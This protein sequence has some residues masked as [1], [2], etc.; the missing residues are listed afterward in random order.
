M[1]KKLIPTLAI[2][3]SI[4][5]G[6]QAAEGDKFLGFEFGVNY[7]LLD[8]SRYDGASM[9]FGLVLPVGQ[10]FD[11][12]VYV[13]KGAFTGKE[14][15]TRSEIETNVTELRFRVPVFESETQSVKLMLGMG[16]GEYNFDDFDD[17]ISGIVGDLGVNYA[18]FKTKS[19]PVKGELAL[20]ALYRW[21]E[22]T[23]VDT[24]LPG[25]TVDSM[26]GFIIGLSAGLY[27]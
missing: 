26:G 25:D 18:F 24:D 1:L 13:E 9:N 12:V 10:K 2:V 4:F 15:D 8:D 11:V 22:I 27:F 3:G 14:D 7:H 16:Y 20:N 17:E 21:S 5:T 6:A 19:G 23:E